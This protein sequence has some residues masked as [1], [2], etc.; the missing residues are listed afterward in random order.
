MH[1]VHI[2]IGGH[3]HLIIPESVETVLYVQCRLQQVELLVLVNHLLCQPERVKR[4]SAQTE[5]GLCVHVAAFRDGTAGRISLGNE[6]RTLQTRVVLP[7][8]RPFQIVQMNTAV[9]ELAVMKIGFLGA[10]PGN[11][12]HS[13][14]RLTFLFRLLYFPEHHFRHIRM[15]VQVIVHILLDKVSHKLVDAD[16]GKRI[17]ISVRILLR[18]HHQ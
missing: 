10:F 5:H 13:G 12:R 3:Y 14:N 16:P 18:S 1:A 8:F 9:T 6:D 17:R 4:L 15:L 2:G 7:L 11:L